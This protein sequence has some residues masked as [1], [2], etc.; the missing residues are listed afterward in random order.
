MRKEI[1]VGT[2][3]SHWHG[4]KFKSEISISSRQRGHSFASYKSHVK[5]EMALN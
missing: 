3:Y 1:N 5:V 4:L 2:W